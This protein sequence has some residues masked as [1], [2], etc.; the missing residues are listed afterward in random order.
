MDHPKRY[1]QDDVKR[2]VK[3][4]IAAGLSV[5]R[6]EICRDGKIVIVAGAALPAVS[7]SSLADWKA[8]RDA[9]QA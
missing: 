5:G 7:A 6:V 8:R 9:G 4:A 3:G 1:T 2:A